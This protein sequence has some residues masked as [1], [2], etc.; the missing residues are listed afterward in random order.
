MK[1]MVVK[2]I[3][4]TRKASALLCTSLN[5][6]SFLMRI[7][8]TLQVIF[9]VDIDFLMGITHK[10]GGQELIPTPSLDTTSNNIKL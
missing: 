8:M 1:R 2:E 5:E 9:V 7:P 3:N 6:D 4:I 10:R